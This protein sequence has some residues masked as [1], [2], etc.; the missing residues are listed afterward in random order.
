MRYTDL[1]T[2]TEHHADLTIEFQNDRYAELKWEVSAT[3]GQYI[4]ELMEGDERI[5]A[6]VAYIADAEDDPLDYTEYEYYE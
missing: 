2:M 6:H 3:Q 5:V 1:A 4:L